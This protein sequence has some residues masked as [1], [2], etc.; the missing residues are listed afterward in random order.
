M[1]Y[2]A[3]IKVDV[4]KSETNEGYFIIQKESKG[5]NRF[6]AKQNAEKIDYGFEIEENTVYLNSYFLTEFG[7]IWKEEDVT[8]IFYLPESNYVYFDNSTKYFLYRVD[9]EKDMFDSDMAKHHFIMTPSTL[10]CTDC[11]E[12]EDDNDDVKEII[13][14]EKEEIEKDSVV[15]TQEII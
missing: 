12:E 3:N 9:N 6:S 5:K 14:I 8:I 4:R 1:I 13:N 10:R 7:N 15:T 11:L 2:A